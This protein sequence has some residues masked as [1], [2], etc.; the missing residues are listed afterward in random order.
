[1]NGYQRLSVFKR[2]VLGDS[3]RSVPGAEREDRMIEIIEA[4]SREF[5]ADTRNPMFARVATMYPGLREGCGVWLRPFVSLS[6]VAI[7]EYGQG[8]YSLELTEG[9]D[10][11]A[12]ADPAVPGGPYLRLD[13]LASSTLFS[14]WS[15]GR[16]RVTGLFGYSYEKKAT[17]VTVPTGGLAAAATSLA[18]GR[19]HGIDLGET[20]II[21]DEQIEVEAASGADTLTLGRGINGTTAA[22]HAEGTVIYRRVYPADVVLGVTERARYLWHNEFRGGQEPDSLGF[23]TSSWPRWRRLVGKYEIPGGV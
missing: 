11:E 16:L 5:D 12:W 7:D 22:A 8:D 18:A 15:R 20:L 19:D 13:R 4:V 23:A 2:N 1:M 6:A 3:K 14:G 9:E 17:G 21:G 10:F